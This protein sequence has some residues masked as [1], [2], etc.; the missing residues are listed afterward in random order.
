MRGENIKIG[1]IFKQLWQGVRYSKWLFFSAY[2]LYFFATV[3]QVF[4]PIYY[5]RFFDF[6]S[7]AT[8]KPSI[9]GTLTTIIFI[10]LFLH[11]LSWVFW[12][13]G[14]VLYNFMM[15][16]TTAKLKQY[17]FDYMLK[18]S[19]SFFTNNFTGSLVQRVNR[20]TRA[21]ETLSNSMVYQIIPLSVTLVGSVLVTWFIAPIVS[22]LIIAWVIV[23]VIFNLTF[24][25]WKLKYDLAVATADSRTTGYLSDS[26]TNNSAVSL[27]TGTNYESKAFNK[28][29]F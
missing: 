14:D 15:A 10:I 23:F 21:F 13:V 24:S 28:R 26:I 16:R 19:Y 20:F 9:V 1:Q 18:H 5:K 22:I 4:I 29:R 7:Q 12:R 6:L 17:P 25:W 27:F 3:V 2:F 11:L 8:D